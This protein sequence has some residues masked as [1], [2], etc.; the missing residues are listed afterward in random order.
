MEEIRRRGENRELVEAVTALAKK[1]GIA[2]PYTS[3]LVVP[4]MPV[5]I[6][7]PRPPVPP[8]PWPVRPPLLEAGGLKQTVLDAARSVQANAG[9]LP[10]NRGRFEDERFARLPAAP[11]GDA[12]VAAFADAREHKRTYD[13]ARKALESGAIGKVQ[14]DRLG[15]ELSIR[16]ND[17]KNQSQVQQSAVRRAAGRTLQEIGGVWIDST[18]DSRTPVVTVKAMS[19]AYFRLLDRQP[20]LCEAFRLANYL[21]WIAPNGTALVIDE[22]DGRESL[23]DKEIDT[24]FQSR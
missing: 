24:L 1:Y 23:T 3:W 19:D 22:G 5:P 18:F 6:V 2:T 20:Q 11:K 15:V 10:A 8:R 4:D 14:A 13:A 9:D 12:S 17:L 21:V 16:G 7:R